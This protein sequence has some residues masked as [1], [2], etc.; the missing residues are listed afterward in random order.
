MKASATKDKKAAE[1][2]PKAAPKK[3]NQKGIENHLTLAKHLEN[4]AKNHKEAAQHHEQGNHKKA[5]QST[6]VAQGHLN[7]ANKAQKKDTL[8]HATKG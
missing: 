8:Q 2:S 5:A 1:R 7:L 6:I 4:A 3:E